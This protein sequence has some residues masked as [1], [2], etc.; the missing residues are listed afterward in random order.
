[1]SIPT[2][3]KKPKRNLPFLFLNLGMS[4]DG[5]IASANGAI[6]NF[7]SKRDKQHLME[8]RTYADAVM[9]GA[10]TVDLNSVTL[11]PGSEKYRKMRLRR[12]LAEY[13][14]RVIVS[15]SGSIDPT[16]DIFRHRFSPI[17][18]LTTRSVSKRRL[19]RLKQIADEV[20]T[21]GQKQLDFVAA[22]RWLREK[23]KVKRLLCE[24]GG[25]LNGALFRADLVDE[26]HLT[27]CPQIIGGRNAPTIA[28]GDNVPCLADAKQ[29][30]LASAKR[31]GDEMFLVYRR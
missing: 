12:G 15:G 20:K 10:R 4:A 22:F 29:F 25:E 26:I 31:I 24:G 18:I 19:E 17:I 23:W 16:A 14:L 8:L 1:M 9:S 3:N 13:N 21:F 5:K 2:V 27:L 6:P 28:D 11:G 30:K 7:G